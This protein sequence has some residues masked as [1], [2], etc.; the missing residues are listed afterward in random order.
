M[1]RKIALQICSSGLASARTFATN[2]QDIFNTVSWLLLSALHHC[3]SCFGVL[4]AG[5]S[6]LSIYFVEMFAEP[7]SSYAAPAHDTEQL[8]HT[9]RFHLRELRACEPS[10]YQHR[11][12]AGQCCRTEALHATQSSRPCISVGLL[13]L[14]IINS[15]HHQMCCCHH[16]GSKSDD[17]QRS[18]LPAQE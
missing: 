18:S 12:L 4:R 1:K 11:L 14:E 7:L 5:G 15:C 2:S 16:L 9:L 6:C 3:Q 8:G 13:V 10:P 17:I